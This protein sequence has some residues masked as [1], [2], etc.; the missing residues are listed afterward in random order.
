MWLKYGQLYDDIFKKEEVP[1]FF[2]EGLTFLN[3]K[4]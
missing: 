1:S 4:L 3:T 2:K